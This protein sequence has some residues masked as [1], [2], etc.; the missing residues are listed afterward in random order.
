MSWYCFPD[1]SILYIKDL[2]YIIRYN[3]VLYS[4]VLYR[5]F[6]TLQ[7]SALGTIYAGNDLQYCNVGNERQTCNELL[8]PRIEGESTDFVRLRKGSSLAKIWA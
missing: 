6:D 7:G 2:Y 3:T 1:Y 5:H 4:V 8:V